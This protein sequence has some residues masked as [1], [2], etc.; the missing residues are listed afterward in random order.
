MHGTHPSP[1][2]MVRLA[3]SALALS[4]LATVPACQSPTTDRETDILTRSVVDAVRREVVDAQ[5][6]PGYR[7][8][9]RSATVESLKIP[10]DRLRQLESTSG[11]A[12]YDGVEDRLDDDLLGAP[13]QTVRVSLERAI[14]SAAERNLELQFERLNPAVSEAELVQASA[15][16]DW[17]FFVNGQYQRIDRPRTSTTFFGAAFDGFQQADT[18]TGLRRRLSTGG[19]FQ[20][21]TTWSWQQNE[22]PGITVVPDPANTVTVGA[23]LTQPLLRGAGSEVALASVR[24]ATNAERE[25]V[26]RLKASLI[27]TLVQTEEAYWNLALATESLRIQRRLL[28]R[29]EK[30]R[31]IIVDRE[32]L[33]ATQAQIADARAEVENRR[34][35][36]IRAERAVRQASDRLKVLIN[37]PDLTIGSELLILPSDRAVDEPIRFSLADALTTAYAERPEVAQ[38]AIS[39]DST[40]IRMSVA[41]NG[42]LPRLDLTLQA[43]YSALGERVEE[44]YED[45]FNG[46][47]IDYIFGLV[48]EQPIGNREANAVVRQRRLEQIQ[49]VTSYQ[50]TVQQVTLEVKNALRDVVTGYELIAQTRTARVAAAENLR[51]L[52][53][54]IETTG[55]Y[56]AFNLDQWLTRQQLLATAEIGE[57]QAL[58]NYNIAIARLYASIGMSPDRNGIR[59][60]VPEYADRD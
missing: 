24:L 49:A 22:N 40:G 37:D 4:V 56:D 23:Q 41:R 48:F 13:Q 27:S 14:R 55:G 12:S 59:F 2:V 8:T 32:R 58:A 33:D 6:E 17:T 50:N 60:V 39:L 11:P 44:A 53:V 36:I 31:D 54:Q 16:F 52:Q 5:G 51:A 35:E 26:Q 28:E 7:L 45:V 43:R 42:V 47:F 30:V 34:A 1:S 19:T 20:V 21:E 9:E 38:A 3:G 46:R 29:G 15:A 25:S 18:S 10:A 57:L